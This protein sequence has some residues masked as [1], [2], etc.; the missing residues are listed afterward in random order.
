[1]F[2]V[3]CFVHRGGTGI[4]QRRP[5]AQPPFASLPPKPPLPDASCCA[6]PTPRCTFED[7]HA[8]ILANFAE[9]VTRQ[10]EKDI[11]IAAHERV[12]KL[13]SHSGDSR[14]ASSDA[15][16]SAPSITPPASDAASGVAAARG[17]GAAKA[18]GAG[19]P[20]DDGSCVLCVDTAGGADWKVVHATQ[21]VAEVAG[22]RPARGGFAA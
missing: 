6:D 10:L 17:G 9:L 21:S 11:Q 7:R 20:S 19:G 22:A 15:G 2:V 3:F 1:M 4:Q 13:L 5:P 14:G 16:Y 12:Q 8:L 18:A